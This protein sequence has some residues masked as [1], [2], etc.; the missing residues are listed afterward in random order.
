MPSVREV[1]SRICARVV[2]ALLSRFRAQSRFPQGPGNPSTAQIGEGHGVAL[3]QLAQRVTDSLFEAVTGGQSVGR[4]DLERGGRPIFRA[5]AS[6][7]GRDQ[8]WL[9]ADEVVGFGPKIRTIVREVVGAP[10]VEAS[11]V[12]DRAHAA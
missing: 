1:D 12:G 3:D 7:P 6:E 5:V 9:A 4:T 2:A 11:R 8:N 10:V